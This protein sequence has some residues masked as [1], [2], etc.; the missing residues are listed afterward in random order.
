MDY[1]FREDDLAHQL[2]E[3]QRKTASKIDAIPEDR[4]RVSSDQ[5]IVENVLPQL[6][7]EPITLQLDAKTINPPTETTVDGSR[8][9]L[10]RRHPD[11][12]HVMS[13]PR[14]GLVPGTRVDIDIPIAGAQFVGSLH[15]ATH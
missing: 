10:V 4:F 12:G 6:F 11:G 15:P 8:G 9:P 2:R 1:L 14:Q 13:P 5:E 7:V 3:R